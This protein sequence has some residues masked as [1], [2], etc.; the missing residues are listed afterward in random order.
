M[1]NE[2]VIR[3]TVELIAAATVAAPAET[4]VQATADEIVDEI[5]RV[6]AQIA[7]V[8]TETTPWAVAESEERHNEATEL[9]AVLETH[10]D[11]LDPL[12]EPRQPALTTTC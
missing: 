2:P 8:E 7:N 4:I 5:A 3:V 1:D 10:L 11:L 12:E 6:E 9:V